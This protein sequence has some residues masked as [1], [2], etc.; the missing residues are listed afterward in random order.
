MVVNQE[1]YKKIK[2][3]KSFIS[4]HPLPNQKG[5]EASKSIIEYL[6]KTDEND[7]ILVF[8]SGGGSSLL[9]LYSLI[10]ISL[11]K[12]IKLHFFLY[13][14]FLFQAVAIN[15]FIKTKILKILN[16]EK[17]LLLEMIILIKE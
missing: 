8:I 6:K 4:S 1:N 16:L 15:L 12:P 7:L 3:F 2:N 14:Y 17:L 9:F 5:I 10:F 11:Y 13:C